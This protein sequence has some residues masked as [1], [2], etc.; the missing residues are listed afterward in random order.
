MQITR[1]RKPTDQR[2]PI[3]TAYMCVIMTRYNCGTQLL[4]RQNY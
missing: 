1:K 4:N 3:R 2:S